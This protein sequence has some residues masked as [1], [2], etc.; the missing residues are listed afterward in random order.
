[1]ENETNLKTIVLEK[2]NLDKNYKNLQDLDYKFDLLL[3]L[4]F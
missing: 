2:N 4:I 1:M 3:L